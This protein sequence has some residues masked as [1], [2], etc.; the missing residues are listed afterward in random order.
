MSNDESFY[1]AILN[2]ANIVNTINS[3][4]HNNDTIQGLINNTVINSF[5]YDITNT[6]HSDFLLQT[7]NL[8]TLSNLNEYIEI[9]DEYD[10]EDSDEDHTVYYNNFLDVPITLDKTEFNSFKKKTVTNRFISLL[11]QNKCNICLDDYAL[12]QKY[13]TLKCK[14]NF[15]EKCIQKWLCESSIYC[16]TCRSPQKIRD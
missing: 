13:I 11:N 15:H 1:D 6:I 9:S 5:N 8:L 4:N 3:P 16:P 2:I 14:H 12:K 7:N 10:S